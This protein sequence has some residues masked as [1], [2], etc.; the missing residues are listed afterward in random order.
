M[1]RD[2]GNWWVMIPEPQKQLL[3]KGKDVKLNEGLAEL[4]Y[5]IFI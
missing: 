3:S 1:I 4:G 2:L 5:K